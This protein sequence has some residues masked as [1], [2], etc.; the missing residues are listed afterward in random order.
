MRY[1][2]F[3]RKSHKAKASVLRMGGVLHDFMT[4]H[5]SEDVDVMEHIEKM[6][7]CQVQLESLRQQIPEKDFKTQIIMTLPLSWK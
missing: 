6:K 3:S 5:A 7:K 4:T 2:K 1:G